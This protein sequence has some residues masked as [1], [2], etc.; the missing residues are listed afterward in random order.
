MELDF[1][2]LDIPISDANLS[3][4]TSG[5]NAGNGNGHGASGSA[6]LDMSRKQGRSSTFDL[7]GEVDGDDEGGAAGLGTTGGGLGMMDWQSIDPGGKCF[8]LF[9]RAGVSEGD[10][11]ENIERNE[12][13]IVAVASSPSSLSLITWNPLVVLTLHNYALTVTLPTTLHRHTPNHPTD[14]DFSTTFPSPTPQSH[15]SIHTDLPPASPHHS[16]TLNGGI[17]RNNGFS[18]DDEDENDGLVTPSTARPIFGAMNPAGSGS[19]SGSG[20]A[21]MGGGFGGMMT[22]NGMDHSHSHHSNHLQHQQQ[23]QLHQQQNQSYPAQQGTHFPFSQSLG[24]GFSTPTGLHGFGFGAGGPENG[25]N[26]GG[27]PTFGIQMP[28]HPSTGLGGFGANVNGNIAAGGHHHPGLSMSMINPPRTMDGSMPGM[29]AGSSL[30]F[31]LNGA[32]GSSMLEQQQVQTIV[33]SA[34]LWPGSASLPNLGGLY[35]GHQMGAGQGGSGAK[36]SGKRPKKRARTSENTDDED[37]VAG[38]GASSK[39]KQGGVT[40][41]EK[42]TKEKSGGKKDAA[43]ASAAVEIKVEA[44]DDDEDSDA[45]GSDGDDMDES[46][47]T[48]GLV[49]GML[50]LRD[51][52]VVDLS[53]DAPSPASSGVSLVSGFAGVHVGADGF[54]QSGDGM[55][56]DSALN[57]G[58][59][60]TD[61][62]SRIKSFNGL[63][64]KKK[65][66]PPG[67]FKPWN[68]SPSSSHLPSGSACINPVTGEV[69]LPPMDNLTKEEIRKVKNRA[70]AQRSRTRK[71]ELLGGLMDEVNRLRER[72]RDVTNG[73]E[74][75]DGDD[76]SMGAEEFLRKTHMARGGSVMSSS[77][78]MG[79]DEEKEGMKMLIERL[80]AEVDKERKARETAEAQSWMWKNKHDQLLTNITLGAGKTINPGLVSDP[81][82]S[83]RNAQRD[84]EDDIPTSPLGELEAMDDVDEDEL[85]ELPSGGHLDAAR[86][87]RSESTEDEDEGREV[88]QARKRE[89][90]IVKGSQRDSKGVLMMVSF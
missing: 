5:S 79:R 61:G 11:D 3:H 57:G 35:Q 49:P 46:R 81:P 34:A 66:P 2:D 54:R 24:S 87:A 33:P 65:I 58:Q 37:A 17:R 90:A 75:G 86:I 40:G 73:A 1:D 25:M 71:G 70:S 48:A 20:L 59:D 69:E 26:G 7:V 74:G 45:E 55:D 23:Q 30:M 27:G 76:A 15:I 6:G 12:V 51:G 83:V 52:S 63:N 60:G 31:P 13:L 16:F 47:E 53:Q 72:L 88:I 56:G 78:S 62:K 64:K 43:I 29:N 9:L 85:M 10:D 32:N 39:G 41:A 89:K 8:V 19:G 38:A 80:R 84:E 68:T 18:G 44:N 21:G 77:G 14:F 36:G 4:L 82:A 67:G 42:A 28:S 50:G 22:P